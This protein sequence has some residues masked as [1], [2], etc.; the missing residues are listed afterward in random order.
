LYS[1]SGRQRNAA[2]IQTQTDNSNPTLKRR[3]NVKRVT[4]FAY[5]VASYAVFLVTFLYAIGFLGNFAVPKSIDSGRETSLPMAI[6]TNA[7]L[8]GIFAMQ[9]SIMARKW[10]KRAWTQIVPEPAERSTYVL[11]SSVCMIAMFYFWEP[12]GGVIW[13]VTHPAARMAI[14]AVFFLGFAIVLVSTF[15]INHFDLF[16]LRQVYLYLRNTRYTPLRFNTPMFYRYV[17]HPL[18]FG[19]LLAFWAAPTMTAA[20]LLFALAT[21]AYIF[22]AIQFEERDLVRDHGELYRRYKQKTP[23]IVPLGKAPA[24]RPYR[25]AGEMPAAAIE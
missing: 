20:H 19:W 9:H 6:L 4:I 25:T 8:L 22:I 16:G 5:G 11:F 15:L 1:V 23:M 12:M 17:R 21:T 13:E 24:S 3:I 14:Q 10:F 2:T 18:Y 7:A